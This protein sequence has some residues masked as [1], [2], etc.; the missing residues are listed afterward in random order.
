MILPRVIEHAKVQ[1][2]TVVGIDF[3]IV[4]ASVFSDH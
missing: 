4:V 1:N 3:V 2:W